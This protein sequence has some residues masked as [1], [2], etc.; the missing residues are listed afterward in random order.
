MLS[1]NLTVLT[2]TCIK[3]CFHNLTVRHFISLHKHEIDSEKSWQ[4][5]TI[6][7]RTTVCVP[8]PILGGGRRDLHHRQEMLQRL[9]PPLVH[10]Y[11]A[12]AVETRRRRRRHSD[13]RRH[14]GQWTQSKGKLLKRTA[15]YRRVAAPA[16][17]SMGGSDVPVIRAA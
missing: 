15:D 13:S 3:I 11:A 10:D 16:P 12:A 4:T 8:G 14:C 1:L 6:R 2:S 17:Y 7:F 5:I 9:Q